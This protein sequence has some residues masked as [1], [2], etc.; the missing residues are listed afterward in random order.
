MFPAETLCNKIM[1]TNEVP[2][3]STAVRGEYVADS[4]FPD[5]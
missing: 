5:S 3:V 2:P 4:V 1:S